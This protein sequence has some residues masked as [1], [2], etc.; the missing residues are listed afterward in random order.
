MNKNDKHIEKRSLKS[1][2]KFGKLEIL[3]YT[4]RINKKGEYKCKCDCGNITYARTYGLKN[5]KHTSCGCTKKEVIAKIHTLPNHQGLVN[6]LYR[7]YKK[8]AKT[9]NYDFLLNIDEFTVMIYKNCYY[10]NT[11]PLKHFNNSR[12]RKI[13]DHTDFKY[14]GIDRLNNSKGYIDNNC[15]TCCYICNNA[16]NT[17]TEQEFYNWVQKIYNYQKDLKTFND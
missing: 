2:Q 16:K 17:M 9:R 4:D 14:N 1:G 15:V 10:C 8:S 7:S 5:G 6:E 12:S 3:S 13:I 11:E